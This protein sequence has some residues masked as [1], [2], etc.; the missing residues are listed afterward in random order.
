MIGLPRAASSTRTTFV[1]MS[2][3]RARTP[4]YERLEVGEQRVVALDR[5]HRLPRLD[6]VAV[7][8]RVH[9]E[10]VPVVRAELEDRDRL[11]HAAEMRIPLLEHLHHDAR[12]ATVLQQRRARMVEVRIG[13]VALAHLLDGQIEHFG[14][15][16]LV[17]PF[18][19][20]HD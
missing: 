14:R 5:H 7:V 20:S 6:A 3:R 12:M 13:V 2:V 8:E 18:L 1:V 4:R 9:R 10:L 11:V 16:P 17:R 19:K 15:E